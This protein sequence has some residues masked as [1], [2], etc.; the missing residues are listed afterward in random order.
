AQR[1]I[2]LDEVAHLV[3][4]KVVEHERG[5]ENEAPGERQDARI[6]AGAPAARLVA[7]VDALDGNAELGR[8]AAARRVEIALRLAL[9]EVAD[10]P[11][12]VRGFARDA[13]QALAA[14]VGLG[15]YRAAHAA[16][17]NDAV[18]IAAQRHVH[19]MR[20]RRCFRQP[21]EPRRDPAA[22]LLRE[23]FGFLNAAARRHGENHLARGGVDPQRV[24]SRL[25]MTAQP[26]EMDRLVE[27]DLNDR[28]LA[29]TAIEQRAKRHGLHLQQPRRNT[30]TPARARST[31]ADK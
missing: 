20:E 14:V 8:V 11:V 25:A 29:R 6:R 21:L 12:E 4:G 19:P 31:E 22:V 18:R 5:G 30:A 27:Y 3:R 1:M 23:L 26:H 15:P 16:A 2:E 10:A 7:H 13:E 17:M 24:A 28:G 9:E